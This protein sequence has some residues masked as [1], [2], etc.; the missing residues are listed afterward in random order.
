MKPIQ[1]YKKLLLEFGPQLWWPVTEKGEFAPTYRERKRLSESQRFEICIGAILTQNT[2]WKNVMKALGNLS[3][4]GM[5]SCPKIAGS[6]QEEIAQLV[7]PSGYFNQKAKKLVFF[8]QY[9]KKNY[10]CSVKKLFK[11]PIPE[12]RAE[13]LSLH[14]IGNETADD[15]IL[16]AAE[17]PSFVVD[18]Y[19]T[20]FLGRFFGKGKLSYVEAKSFFESQLPQNTQLFNEFHAL[21]VEHG[22]RFC[23]KKPNCAHCF[24][25]ASCPFP[26]T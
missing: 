18:V 23:R 13:L 14:G 7:K 10:S 21:L 15:I 4:A 17:K 20:R 3:R 16:Y 9:L 5:L 6:P 26:N 1:I 2:D 25:K 12:L 11:K 8:S 22:K 19:T 24:L